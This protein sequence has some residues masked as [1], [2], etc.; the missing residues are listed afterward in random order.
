MNFEAILE[1]FSVFAAR[2]G[3]APLMT[4]SNPQEQLDQ[5]PKDWAI[6]EQLGDFAFSLLNVK[7][8]ATQIAPPGSRALTLSATNA[9]VSK[10]A[11]MVNLEFAHIHN[12]PSGSLHLTL[13]GPIRD[14]AIGKGWAIR[15]PMALAGL[16]SPDVVFVYAPRD[17]AELSVAKALLYASYLYAH[18]PQDRL[19]RQIH[20]IV[21]MPYHAFDSHS[22][23]HM[24]RAQA[25]YISPFTGIDSFVMPKPFFGPHPHAGM[26]AVTVML[27]EAQGGFVNRDSLGDTS[28]IHPGDLHWTQAGRG[29]MHEE[30]PEITGLAA[31]GLQVFVNL[32]KAN[33]QADPVAFHVSAKD[34]PVVDLKGASVRVVTGTFAQQQS[35]INADPR[36]LTRVNILDISLQ[37]GASI[38]IPVAKDDN[39][40]FVLR[41][42]SVM[43]P[44]D[45]GSA[46]LKQYSDPVALVFDAAGDAAQISAGNQRLRGVF[47]SG[48]PINEPMVTRGP[49]NANSEQDMNDFIRRFQTGEMGSLSKSF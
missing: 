29:M 44:A 17:L 15:H 34:I 46:E 31:H 4:A 7:E 13:P 41:S 43:A 23:A 48:T 38:E 6:I 32:T 27:P 40:F 42:G 24:L 47:F 3:P 18:K 36:W 49:F 39:A 25:A 22:G 30:T 45:P 1:D 2:V 21:P 16:V 12:P 20:A 11:F 9:S 8:A 28:L 26:S 37:A 10:D 5:F 19:H 14:A 35:P 33:K